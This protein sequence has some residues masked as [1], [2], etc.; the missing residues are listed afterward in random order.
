MA[1]FGTTSSFP[2]RRNTSSSADPFAAEEYCGK[3]GATAMRSTRAATRRD[4][5]EAIDGLP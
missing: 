4:S 3:S 1:R 5:A 2:A